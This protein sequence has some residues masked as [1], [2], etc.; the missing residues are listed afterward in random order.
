VGVE[1]LSV[2]LQA[3]SPAVARFGIGEFLWGRGFVG[4]AASLLAHLA[5]N[6]DRRVL[7]GRGFVACALSLLACS[8][9][10]L[11]SESFSGSRVCR[12]C[13]PLADFGWEFRSES[14]CGVE[15][16]SVVLQA[17]SPYLFP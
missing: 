8:G 14:F 6:S 12:G 5:E 3:R 10:E 16:L 7:R 1:G 13:F 17:G 2:V 15:A 4:G 11:G 9:R